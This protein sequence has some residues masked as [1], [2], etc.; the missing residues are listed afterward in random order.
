MHATLSYAHEGALVILVL[1]RFFLINKIL[2]IYIFFC[3]Y[4]FSLLFLECS[5]L[6]NINVQDIF[7]QASQLIY[8]FCVVE[9]DDDDE[10]GAFEG[11]DDDFTINEEE[12]DEDEE[13]LIALQSIISPRNNLQQP[14]DENSIYSDGGTTDMHTQAVSWSSNS[15]LYK[16]TT[17]TNL[18]GTTRDSFQPYKRCD[19]PELE[20]SCW[21]GTA[22]C[23]AV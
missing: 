8:D 17:S 20:K 23:F 13:E 19:S 4:T 12:E 3:L 11:D 6:K 22:L 2:I 1:C 7:H 10:S 15:D 9:E 16:R 5:A 14:V 18:D 21:F